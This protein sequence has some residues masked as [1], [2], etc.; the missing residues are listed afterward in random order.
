V[1]EERFFEERGERNEEI[2]NQQINKS[3]NRKSKINK[4]TNRKSTNQPI[5]K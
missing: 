5:N 3:T 2:K 1:V 4:S